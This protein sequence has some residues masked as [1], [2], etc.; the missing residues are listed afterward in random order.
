M[1]GI[2]RG[3]PEVSMRGWAEV[4]AA[5][6]RMDRTE[7]TLVALVVTSLTMGLAV[8]LGWRLGWRFPQ[9]P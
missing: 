1:F 7:Y 3:Q 4:G 5:V 9:M 8:L 2:G 6:L